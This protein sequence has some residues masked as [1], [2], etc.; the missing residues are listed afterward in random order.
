MNRQNKSNPLNS[1]YSTFWDSS[2]NETSVDELLG[3]E[4]EQRKGKDPVKLASYKRAISNFVNILTGKSIPVK[5]SGTNSYTDGTMI[6]I[7]SNLSEKNFDPTVG[8]AL[9]EAAHNLLTDF[10][11]LKN[12]EI[13]IPAELY[14]LGEKKGLNRN[15]VIAHIKRM[16]NYVEDR[17]IDNFIFTTS[18]GYKGYY[19]EMYRTYFYSTVID[20]MLLSINLRDLD[21]ESYE[22]RIINLHNKN[23]QL[24]ALPGL[25]EIYSTIDFKNIDR[26]ENTDAAFTV[27]CE[28]VSIVLNNIDVIKTEL[29]EDEQTLKNFQTALDEFDDSSETGEGSGDDSETDDDDS[30]DSEAGGDITSDGVATN[31]DGS[32]ASELTDNQKSQLKKHLEKQ[33]KFMDGDIK[34]TTITKKLLHDVEAIEASGA[35]YVNVGSNIG[36]IGGVECL[37]VKKFSKRLVDSNQFGVC[38]SMNFTS[39]GHR[40]SKYNYVEEGLRLGNILGKKLQVRGEEN[41]LKFT[42]KNA[43]RLDRR[44]IAELGFGNSNVFSQTFVTKYN[45]A[46]LHISVD[47]SGSMYG[48]NWNNA[49]TSAI[50][51]IKAADMVGNIEVVMSVRTTHEVSRNSNIPF[52]L[53]CYDS[54]TDK[55]SKINSLFRYLNA[56][57]TTPEGLCFEAIMK[58]LIPGNSNQDSYFINYSD[59]SPMFYGKKLHYVGRLAEM[60]TKKMVDKMRDLGIKV[61]SYFIDSS[62]SRGSNYCTQTFKNMYG[63]DAAFIEATNMMDVAKTM[64][65]KFLEI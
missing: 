60:H 25:R 47:A 10:D 23:T 48:V 44:L 56:T 36:N 38:N 62:G 29:S 22:A 14:V 58:D 30:D 18:P 35:N 61:M 28:V 57:G 43:G 34:K 26:L 20:K 13:N 19:H 8:L 31:D 37:V 7:S 63:S 27:A 3:F 9:H 51:M 21:I 24:S 39:Y 64:N 50:A 32:D 55:L 40:W 15:S 42:R 59:G 4:V 17:R 1:T 11:S 2:A 33:D 65:K 12:L 46:Y 52:I 6:N 54:R 5:F 16:L 41:S 49:M 53:V 45:K